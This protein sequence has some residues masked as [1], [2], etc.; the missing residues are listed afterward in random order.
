MREQSN[1]DEHSAHQLNP[2]AGPT[3][4]IMRPLPAKQAQHFAGTMACKQKS[5]DDSKRRIG[6]WFKFLESVHSDSFIWK[7]NSVPDYSNPIFSNFRRK[8]GCRKKARCAGATGF[9]G[10]NRLAN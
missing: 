7:L 9:G 6:C 2:C 4:D 5:K 10:M 3:Q 8:I 1:Q